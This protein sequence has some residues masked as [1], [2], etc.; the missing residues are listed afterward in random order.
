MSLLAP[1]EKPVYLTY[2]DYPIEDLLL[3]AGIDCIVTSGLASKMFP[4]LV[5]SPDFTMFEP[6]DKEVAEFQIKAPSILDTYIKYTTPAHEFLLDLEINGFLYDVDLNASMKADM[7]KEISE[8]DA[9]IFSSIKPINLD[10]GSEIAA[11]IYGELGIEPL[12]FTKT[13]DPSTDGDALKAL[14][15]EH[16]EYSWL[17]LLAKRNDIAS[18]YRTFVENYVRDFV[19]PDGRIHPSYNQFGTSSFRISGSEP[20]LTQLPRPKHGY[21]V[22]KLFRVRDGHLF[23]AFDFSSAEV[24]ILGALSKDENLL[25]YIAMGYDFHSASAAAM[26]GIDYDEFVE[27]LNSEDHPLKK[28]YKEKRQIAKAST[29]YVSAY[30][31]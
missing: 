3:Y 8:L 21:N 23:M 7:Q 11:L 2:E 18:I 24:K 30:P 15:K 25:R 5:Y 6:S 31:Q 10:S 19:K 12:S 16:P 9:L 4:D 28:D 13:G 14:T 20:N 17:P 1:K 27:I 29:K 22:R 26:H